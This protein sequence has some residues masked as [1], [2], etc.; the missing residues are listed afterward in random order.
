MRSPG[1]PISA[2]SNIYQRRIKTLHRLQIENQILQTL[3]KPVLSDETPRT[4]HIFL[5]ENRS[6]NS[7]SWSYKGY[8]KIYATKAKS[9]LFSI[10]KKSLSGPLF[11]FIKT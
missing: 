8:E 4:T 10:E 1:P 6:K 7:K 3:A 2:P 9:F 5:I 11:Y